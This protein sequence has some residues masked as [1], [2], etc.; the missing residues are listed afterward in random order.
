M[1]PESISSLEAEKR[2]DD[3]LRALEKRVDDLIFEKQ[4]KEFWI[5]RLRKFLILLTTACLL[6]G[7]YK[8]ILS[9]F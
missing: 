1:G 7:C 8:L 2:A 4:M 5:R 9:F 6:Y 3:A